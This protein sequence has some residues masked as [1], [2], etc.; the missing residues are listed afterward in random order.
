[1]DESSDGQ[2]SKDVNSFWIRIGGNDLIDIIDKHMY[3]EQKW[4][5]TND[6]VKYVIIFLHMAMVYQGINQFIHLFG[7]LVILEKW[8]WPFIL[9][10]ATFAYK[11]VAI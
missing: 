9:A 11:I 2:E 10:N 5:D 6:K 7:F 8:D 4:N 1:M 3:A